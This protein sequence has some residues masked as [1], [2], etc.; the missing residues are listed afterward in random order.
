MDREKRATGNLYPE[1]EQKDSQGRKG[2]NCPRKLSAARNVAH[3]PVSKHGSVV[4]NPSDSHLLPLPKLPLAMRVGS[5]FI[6]I[7]EFPSGTVGPR[8]EIYN[9]H[10]R[11][12]TLPTDG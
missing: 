7:D 11:R 1:N 4:A 10:R 6:S 5:R 2:A 8:A 12:H 9:K 3:E